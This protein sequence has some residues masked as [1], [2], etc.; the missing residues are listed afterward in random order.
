MA[1]ATEDAEAADDAKAKVA[2][3]VKES[4]GGKR[5]VK[6]TKNEDTAGE[7]EKAGS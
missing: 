7:A 2:K 1:K 5:A 4:D 6:A 3:A